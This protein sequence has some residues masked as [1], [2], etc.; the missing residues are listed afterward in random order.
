MDFFSLSKKEQLEKLPEI[1]KKAAE[2][3]LE[4]NTILSKLYFKGKLVPLDIKKGQEY[5][6]Y[7]VSNNYAPAEYYLFYYYRLGKNGYPVNYEKSVQNLKHAAAQNYTLAVADLGVSY[8]YGLGDIIKVNLE[9]AARCAFKAAKQGNATAQRN[10]GLKYYHGDGI[11]QNYAKAIEWF[12]RA[13]RFGKTDAYYD[14]GKCYYYGH[15]V[16]K[17]LDRAF[18]L[19]MRAA[20]SGDAD[21]KKALKFHK[22]PYLNKT[23][24]EKYPDIMTMDFHL[25]DYPDEFDDEIEDIDFSKEEIEEPQNNENKKEDNALKGKVENMLGK[26]FNS[27]KM[28]ELK[29]PEEISQNP[30]AIE[31]LRIIREDSDTCKYVIGE[32]FEDSRVWGILMSD[33]IKRISEA[34]E[35]NG[36]NKDLTAKEILKVIELELEQE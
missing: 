1:E 36:F 29:I 2:G 33:L 32:L 20:V 25:R 4:C 8:T 24:K 28:K 22:Q 15:G 10:L 18:L 9:K 11:K 6:D 34:Y 21:A 3:D 13:I 27:K 35:E 16:E 17:D 12:T 26:F 5:L 19:M 30:N 7:A 14:L 31:I 23:I